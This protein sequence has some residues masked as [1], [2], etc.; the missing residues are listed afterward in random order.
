MKWATK[1][2][3]TNRHCPPADRGWPNPSPTLQEYAYANGRTT[4][5]LSLPV[6]C[7]AAKRWRH[8]LPAR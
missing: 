4:P 6:F 8:D 5:C 7:S 3:G 1:H 2:A